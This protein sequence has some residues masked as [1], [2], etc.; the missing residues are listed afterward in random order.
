MSAVK[1]VNCTT[2]INYCVLPQKHSHWSNRRS[3]H[4]CVCTLHFCKLSASWPVEPVSGPLGAHVSMGNLGWQCPSSEKDG[5][6]FGLM[7]TKGTV[8]LIKNKRL[9]L[10]G[11]RLGSPGQQRGGDSEGIVGRAAAGMNC[12]QAGDEVHGLKNNND[13]GWSKN[14]EEVLW[15]TIMTDGGSSS[16]NIKKMVKSTNKASWQILNLHWCLF[17]ISGNKNASPAWYEAKPK[18]PDDINKY[19]DKWHPPTITTRNRSV[20]RGSGMLHGVMWF[21]LFKNIQ[22]AFTQSLDPSQGRPNHQRIQ[23][24]RQLKTGVNKSQLEGWPSQQREV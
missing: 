9:C 14:P 23:T 11:P 20:Q 10:W 21:S 22:S 12:S 24:W 8:F 1:K 6:R 4:V 16:T 2:Q 5:L 18:R 3:Y 17:F 15:N 7:Y 19:T 13:K